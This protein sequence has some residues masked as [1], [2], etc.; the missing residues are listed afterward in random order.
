MIKGNEYIFKNDYV[1]IKIKEVEVLISFLDYDLV[2]KYT[3]RITPKG[4]V[5]TTS[6]RKEG[7]KNIRLSRLIMNCPKGKVVDHINSNRLDNI[8]ANLRICSSQQN[9][10]NVAKYVKSKSKYKGVT[11]CKNTNKWRA[12]TKHFGKTISLGYYDTEEEGAKAYNDYML[13]HHKD[14]ARLNVL[15]D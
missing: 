7:R 12:K 2:S 4:Y 10:L 9:N 15:E 6:T 1:I 14:Y 13:R 8:R 3:W 11:Y 5:E